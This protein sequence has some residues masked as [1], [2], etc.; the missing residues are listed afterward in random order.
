MK[1]ITVK[2]ITILIL[3]KIIMQEMYKF[4]MLLRIIVLNQISEKSYVYK[5]QTI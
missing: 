4:R 1:L 5:S 3:I 2:Q